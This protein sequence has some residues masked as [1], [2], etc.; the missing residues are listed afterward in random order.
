MCGIPFQRWRGGITS[1]TL[2]F[3]VRIRQG[4]AISMGTIIRLP[5][6]CMGYRRIVNDRRNGRLGRD[7][8]RPLNMISPQQTFINNWSEE[9]MADI[10][11][12]SQLPTVKDLDLVRMEKQNRMAEIVLDLVGKW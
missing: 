6:S 12:I 10:N 5:I 1:I 4:I 8:S 9:K 3:L 2:V 11:S 7:T